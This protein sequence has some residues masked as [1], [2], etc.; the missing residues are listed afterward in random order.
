MLFNPFKQKAQTH[1]GLKLS[2]D[3]WFSH[4][5]KLFRERSLDESIWE[6]AEEIL[7]SADVGVTTTTKLLE[8]TKQRVLSD[9]ER[10]SLPLEILKDEMRNILKCPTNPSLHNPPIENPEVILVV[11]VNGV[12]KTTSI[13]K[14]GAIL[15]QENKKVLLGAADTFR[16][17]AIDQLKIWG[18]RIGTDVIAHQHGSDPGAVAYDAWQAAKAR[19]IDTLIIDTAGRIHTKSNLM[20]EIKKIGRV[21]NHLDPSAPH[22]TLLVLDAT[23]GQNSLAQ[24]KAFLQ[25]LECT[26]ILLTKLDGTAKG[27]IVLAIYDQLNIPVLYIGTGEGL[28][29][30]VQFTEDDFV[31][32]IFE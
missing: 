1:G 18:Q 17:A 11:G 27:G 10:K 15:C 32:A 13:G 20:E 8:A 29:D 7:L 5:T 24:A 30:L 26:G 12:G 21:L 6:E 19:S 31:E 22:K 14:L 2:R 3:R 25:T 9:K 16:S 4:L 28:N 23:T